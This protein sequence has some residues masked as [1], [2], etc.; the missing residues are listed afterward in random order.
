M[1]A[2]ANLDETNALSKYS[3][4]G[5]RARDSGGVRGIRWMEIMY[6][7]KL[8]HSIVKKIRANRKINQSSVKYDLTAVLFFV[9]GGFKFVFVLVNFY[10]L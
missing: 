6:P 8:I 10:V 2:D 9:G 4:D 7:G 3:S 1:R 5:I